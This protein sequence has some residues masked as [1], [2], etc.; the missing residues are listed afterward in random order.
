MLKGGK[1]AIVNC[2]LMYGIKPG[3]VGNAPIARASSR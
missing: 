1:G 3:D 2:S